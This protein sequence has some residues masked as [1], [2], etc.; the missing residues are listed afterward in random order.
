MDFHADPKTGVITSEKLD[1]KSDKAALVGG[2]L[3]FKE[4]G[5]WRVNPGDPERCT[6]GPKQS[7]QA[8][9]G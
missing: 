2:L 8:I 6:Q 1:D 4:T 3:L 5:A 9:S 7:N